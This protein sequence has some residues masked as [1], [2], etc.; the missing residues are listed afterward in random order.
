MSNDHPV[1]T[2][3]V[4]EQKFTIS[5]RCPH[6]EGRLDHGNV[7]QKRLT[8]TCPLHHSVFC[9]KTGRQLAGPECGSIT[10]CSS[11]NLPSKKGVVV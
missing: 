4:G 11:N 2:L 10:V 9:L 5:Q 7:N 6:R 8:I 1:F 3:S